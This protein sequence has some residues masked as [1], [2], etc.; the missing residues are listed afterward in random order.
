MKKK[1]VRRKKYDKAEMLRTLRRL[2][3][4]AAYYSAMELITGNPKDAFDT[5]EAEIN[6]EIMHLE[7]NE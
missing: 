4:K 5:M 6:E 1:T 7:G 2:R 3:R